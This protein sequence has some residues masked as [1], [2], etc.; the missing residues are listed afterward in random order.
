MS[1]DLNSGVKDAAISIGVTA[2]NVSNVCL[3][4]YKQ[5]G[6]FKFKYA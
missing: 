4:N 5:T 2:P 3:G 6:G 1:D